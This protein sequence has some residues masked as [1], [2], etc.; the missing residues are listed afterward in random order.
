MGKYLFCII[1]ASGSGKTTIANILEKRYGLKQ[2]Q[3]FTTRPKR[4][5]DEVG[6]IFITYP[7]FLQLKDICA[8]DRYNNYEYCATK[9][10]IENNDVYVV[11]PAGVKQ[12]KEKYDGEKKIIT[13]F[14]KAKLKERYLRMRD[15]GDSVDAAL[16]RVKNDAI[17]FKGYDK[18]CSFSIENSGKSTASEIA[19]KIYAYMCKF[20][21]G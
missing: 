2:I 11:N 7:E 10:Q 4:S 3:S 9:E 17:E 14:I 6:H 8:Y 5:P 13:I 20:T 15:R 1:G 21:K 12:L 19:D 16:S 18:K